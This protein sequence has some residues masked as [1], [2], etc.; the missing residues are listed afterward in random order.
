MVENPIKT[1]C[2][3]Q[4]LCVINSTVA[5][6]HP[7]VPKPYIL[8]FIIPKEASHFS[9]LDLKDAFL[10]ILINPDDKISLSLLAQ[11]TQTLTQLIPN[12]LGLP[13]PEVFGT[14]YIYL[15]MFEPL[16]YSFCLLLNSSLYNTLMIFCVIHP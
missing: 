3:F 12:S 7:I 16:A 14:V 2:L 4:D 9:V 11:W 13:C 10:S 6:I 5:P 1:H 8:L 15:A